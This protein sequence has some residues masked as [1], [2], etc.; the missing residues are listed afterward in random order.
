[1]ALI[2]L[3]FRRHGQRSYVVGVDRNN[4]AF[5]APVVVPLPEADEQSECPRT[6]W[7]SDQRPV[8]DRR[9]T[10]TQLDH[11][12]A[13]ASPRPSTQLD[14]CKCIRRLGRLETTSTEINAGGTSAVEAENS[15]IGTVVALVV[16]AA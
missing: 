7:S 14:H 15:S 1:M 6:C 11:M 8:S 3:E 13:Q 10:S 5:A 4:G 16:E 9:W 12:S 2:G